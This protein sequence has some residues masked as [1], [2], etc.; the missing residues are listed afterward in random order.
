MINKMCKT[1]GFKLPHMSKSPVAYH[2][3]G[4]MVKAEKPKIKVQKTEEEKMAEA[5]KALNQISQKPLLEPKPLKPEMRGPI[6]FDHDKNT[7]FASA[8]DTAE[9]EKMPAYTKDTPQDA[10]RKM[11]S[12]HETFTNSSGGGNSDDEELNKFLEGI[13][14]IDNPEYIDPDNPE[15]EA[16]RSTEHDF[17]I[18]NRSKE[19]DSIAKVFMNLNK[20]ATKFRNE[21]NFKAAGAKQNEINDLLKYIKKQNENRIKE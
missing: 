5:R 14:E 18:K 8:D 1:G 7:L 2:E 10:L 21:R 16:P 12:F 19:S 17:F 9:L 20:D 11:P 13:H 15:Y 3:K 6:N 4:H